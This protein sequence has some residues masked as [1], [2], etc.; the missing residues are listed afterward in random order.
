MLMTARRRYVAAQF[1]ELIA[2]CDPHRWLLTLIKMGSR[3]VDNTIPNN[4]KIC[5]AVCRRTNRTNLHL[6]NISTIVYDYNINI[7]QTLL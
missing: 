4:I 1:T 2:H 5:P 6:Y 3:M 7:K